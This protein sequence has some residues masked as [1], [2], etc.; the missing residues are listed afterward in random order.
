MGRV[1]VG[2][3]GLGT[4]GSGVAR[5]LGEHGE[6]VARRAGRPIDLKWA[7]VR[8]ADRPRPFAPEGRGS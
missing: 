3:L 4:V 2:L 5:L 1:T 7:V 6:R 8:D